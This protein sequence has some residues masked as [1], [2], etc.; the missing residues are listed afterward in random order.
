MMSKSKLHS[1]R[2]LQEINLHLRSFT[3]SIG[4]IVRAPWGHLATAVVI[5]LALALPFGTSLLLHNVEQISHRLDAPG[6]ITLYL[7]AGT[8]DASIQAT[9][10][11]LKSDPTIQTVGYISANQ[12]L[13]DFANYTGF[14]DSLAQ[15]SDNPIP[16][17]ITV[18]P[19]PAVLGNP[20]ALQQLLFRV[21]HLPN[22][23]ET[24]LDLTWLKRLNAWIAV[25][26]R[27]S[28]LLAIVFILGILFI[29]GNTIRLATQERREEI[30]VMKL[31]GA[32]D[33]FIRRPFLYLGS[34][35]GLIGGLIAWIML[36]LMILLLQA[37]AS[38]V[39]SLYGSQLI[40]EG[41]D[42]HNSL[43]LLLG[44]ALLGW[45]AAWFSTNRFIR[46]IDQGE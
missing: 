2:F 33:G 38:Q 34:L 26:Q 30:F 31:L 8:P 7:Q 25:G 6:Q 11:N 1:S 35:Y 32:T 18:E 20:A 29:I 22:V 16:P 44:G 36:G 15:L 43:S 14:Q 10:Q 9:I 37:P 39:A 41:L 5:A 46:Q 12:G 17:V 24:Q 27:L 45:L 13:Q 42:A 28:F 21:Q 3:M 4:E 19:M 23:A 40:L